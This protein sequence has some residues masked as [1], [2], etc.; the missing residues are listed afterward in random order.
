MFFKILPLDST[1]QAALSSGP[2][3]KTQ[4]KKDTYILKVA[5]YFSFKKLLILAHKNFT[6][7][8]FTLFSHLPL[9]PPLNFAE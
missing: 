4:N 5:V 9:S 7:L 6:I 2:S 1:M 8:C 3:W